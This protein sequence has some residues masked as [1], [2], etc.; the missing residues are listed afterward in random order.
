MTGPLPSIRLC[1]DSPLAAG[2]EVTLSVGA[3]HYLVKVMRLA[4]GGRLRLFNGRDGEWLAE[5]TS[6]DRKAAVARLL[7]PVRAQAAEPGPCLLFAPVKRANTDLIVEKATELGAAEIRP[8]VTARSI[9]E[10][11]RTD[12]LRLIA[13]EAAEQCGRL[14]LPEIHEPAPLLRAVAAAG[15]LLFCDTDPEAPR[16]V[17]DMAA[18][19]VLVGPEG[20]FTPEERERLLALPEV[21]PVSLGPRTL[22]AETAAI[23]ALAMLGAG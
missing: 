17:A 2:A 7:D 1:V 19:A 13:R 10:R 4:A 3:S 9:A 11:V 15:P 21:R 5:L 14:T 6:V 12:R 8:V 18:R 16:M 22:R 23:V 20:G